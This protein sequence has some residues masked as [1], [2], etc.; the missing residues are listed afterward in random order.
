MYCRAA[1]TEEKGGGWNKLAQETVKKANHEMH[2]ELNINQWRIQGRGPSGLPPPY[3]STKMRPEGPKN[4]F[5]E[6]APPHPYLSLWMTAPPPLIWRSGFAPD[7]LRIPLALGVHWAPVSNS[8]LGHWWTVYQ[9]KHLGGF[10]FLDSF[11]HCRSY[12]NETLSVLRRKV[13]WTAQI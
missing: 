6:T 9:V 5:L 4:I 8:Y 2:D 7:I 3:F 12:M 13:M 10:C 1:Q 11:N